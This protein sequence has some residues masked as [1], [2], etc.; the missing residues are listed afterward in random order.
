MG[1]SKTKKDGTRT[2]RFKKEELDQIDEFL[3]RNPFFDFS[4]LTRVAI[5]RFITNPEL[6]LEPV[7]P[8]VK[9]E[10]ITTQPEVDT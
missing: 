7:K 10:R 6:P 8:A 5:T 9:I 1:Q 2:V 3:S 4:T